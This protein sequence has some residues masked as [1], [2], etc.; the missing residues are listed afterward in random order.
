M[1]KYNHVSYPVPSVRKYDFVASNLAPA[2]RNPRDIASYCRGCSTDPSGLGLTA[3]ATTIQSKAARV[4]WFCR[5]RVLWEQFAGV[6]YGWSVVAVAVA[7]ASLQIAAL[8][9]LW[10]I[11]RRADG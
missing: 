4:R 6:P 3:D 7:S 5:E 10:R 8:I 1:E 9:I 2:Q 11:L